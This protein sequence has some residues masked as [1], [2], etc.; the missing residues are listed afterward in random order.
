M[1][2]QSNGQEQISYQ[3]DISAALT[4]NLALDKFSRE[5]GTAGTVSTS[6]ESKQLELPAEMK[7]KAE[8]ATSNVDVL[9]LY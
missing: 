5:A 1:S 3:S 6:H 8:Q 9:N 4:T 7:S 2:L